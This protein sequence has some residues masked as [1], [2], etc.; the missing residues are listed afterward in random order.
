LAIVLTWEPGSGLGDEAAVWTLIATQPL[1]L[2][3]F[4][5]ENSSLPSYWLAAAANRA[6]FLR[7]KIVFPTLRDGRAE[8]RVG[9]VQLFGTPGVPTQDG[10]VRLLWEVHRLHMAAI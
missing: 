6:A 1:R 7:Y 8:L 9:R 5:A 2:L 3:P 10:G 4:L